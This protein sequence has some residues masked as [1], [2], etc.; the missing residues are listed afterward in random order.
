[1]DDKKDPQEFLAEQMQK[2]NELMEERL[3]MAREAQEKMK[4]WTEGRGML[5]DM[6]KIREEAT[7]RSREETSSMTAKFDKQYEETR[8]YRESLL[9]QLR[10]MTDQM[11][12]IARALEKKS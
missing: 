8:Q 4:E 3:K 7:S 5:P 9:E 10:L 2:Q 12:A 11:S 6:A 1:M